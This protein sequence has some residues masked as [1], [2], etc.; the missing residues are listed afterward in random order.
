MAKNKKDKDTAYTDNS[1]IRKKTKR[2]NVFAF[3]A[4]FLISCL[5]WIYVMNTQNDGYTKTFTLSVDVL[6]ADV[7]LKNKG[8]TV[9]GVPEGNIT[10]TIK[11]KKTDVRKYVEKD[12]RA[13]LDLSKIEKS[14]LITLDVSVETPSALLSVVTVDPPSVNVFADTN[15]TKVFTP[16]PICEASDGKV[17][18]SLP[19]DSRTF[20]ISGPST[21]VDKIAYADVVIPYSDKYKPGDNVTTTDIRLYNAEETILPS[22]YLTFS[23][24]SLIVKVE[25][26]NE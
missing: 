4:C 11:G 17:L 12:F 13:Y 26:I 15:I 5:I 7:L 19:E 1:Q 8:L 20:E 16:T 9:Y 3:I 25:V 22:T 21:Y 23:R 14:G 2:L 18:V 6:N 10:V 24:N